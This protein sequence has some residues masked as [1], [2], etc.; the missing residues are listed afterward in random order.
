MT[1]THSHRRRAAVPG[2]VGG[3][4]AAIARPW[5]AWWPAVL[6]L[7]LG[8][9]PIVTKNSS[10]AAAATPLML[11]TAGYAVIAFSRRPSWSWPLVG[12]LVVIHLAGRGLGLPGWVAITAMVGLTVLLGALLR[13]W[14][15][16]PEAMRWQVRGALVFMGAA[17]ASFF[18]SSDV[19]R[20]VVA[21]FLL[22]HGAWDVVHWRLR[23]VVSRTLA[24]W[25]AVLDVTLGLGILLLTALG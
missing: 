10:V 16:P 22:L 20:V 2:D 8:V 13:R 24:E 9:S 18:V 3:G 14:G 7:G 12:G 23:A 17:V 19:G 1:A 15:P 5:W 6:G 25:C 21:V 4:Y 11:A